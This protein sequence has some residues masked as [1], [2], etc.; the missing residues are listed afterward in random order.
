MQGYGR[1]QGQGGGSR[2]TGVEPDQ[3][4]RV[5]ITGRG[6]PCAALAS[7]SPRLALGAEPQALGCP[8]AR[9]GKHIAVGRSGLG[10]RSDQNSEPA[11]FWAASPM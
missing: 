6:L 1:N 4:A 9:K 2:I 7:P 10:D 8:F 11:A 3:R 5:E